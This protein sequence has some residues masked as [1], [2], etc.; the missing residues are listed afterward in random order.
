MGQ[1][2]RVIKDIFLSITL[3]LLECQ[4]YAW[5]NVQTSFVNLQGN[6][7]T[8]FMQAWKFLDIN[9]DDRVTLAEASRGLW[10]LKMK[11]MN[12]S[13]G[14]YIE[15]YM[16]V[17]KSSSLLCSNPVPDAPSFLDCIVSL[18]R[19]KIT[20]ENSGIELKFEESYM[21]Y[22]SNGGCNDRTPPISYF[23]GN[24]IFPSN[25]FDLVSHYKGFTYSFS[26]DDICDLIT[27]V[28]YCRFSCRSCS[29]KI[30]S[31]TNTYF[32]S[33]NSR[34]KR[35]V[36]DLDSFANNSFVSILATSDWH[37]EP[38]YDVDKES[39]VA[40]YASPTIDNIWHCFSHRKTEAE[41]KLN[42]MSDP[43]LDFI[44][45]HFTAYREIAYFESN[46]QYTNTTQNTLMPLRRRRR[47]DPLFDPVSHRWNGRNTSPHPTRSPGLLFYGGDTQAHDYRQPHLGSVLE[48]QAILELMRKA[49]A[50]MRTHWHA[51]DIFICAGNNDG[52]H[53]AIFLNEAFEADTEAWANA[54]LEADIVTNDINITYPVSKPPY[55]MQDN[56]NI[57]QIEFFKL[58]G[59]YMKRIDP[60][61]DFGLFN[62]NLFAI[63]YNTNFGC[64][65]IV[66]NMALIK[67]RYMIP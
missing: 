7:L 14:S 20:D 51:R 65:N 61:D 1:S 13:K 64:T 66:Q 47:H 21:N 45:S 60:I 9:G 3:I 34:Q 11:P 50:T 17:S 25:C 40:R 31:K 27:S 38:W 23:L 6:V 19:E 39:V 67:V 62:A 58:T 32:K 56:F 2:I 28:G 37:L 57:S 33:A 5:G 55:R 49:I 24:K 29:S 42:S 41:C 16:S 18:S 12:S 52:P 4:A 59:Y 63:M 15:S 8:E 46:V 48:P 43:P 35:R 36:S 22:L 30:S 26:R 44:V 10:P 53:N 54:L